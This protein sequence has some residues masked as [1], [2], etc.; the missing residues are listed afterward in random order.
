[1]SFAKKSPISV[2]AAIVVLLLSTPT[3]SQ[4]SVRADAD[5]SRAEAISPDGS[6][7]VCVGDHCLCI[8]F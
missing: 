6:V 5:S 7:C 8:K 4:A 2:A 3:F 1:M